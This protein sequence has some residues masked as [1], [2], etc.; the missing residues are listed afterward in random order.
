VAV[1]SLKDLPGHNPPGLS[2]TAVLKRAA[3]GDVLIARESH[4]FRTLPHGSVL[5]TSSVRRA[6]QLRWLRP[7]FGIVE[8]RGNVQT[9]LRKLGESEQ[10]AGIIL[11]QAGLERLGYDLGL[12]DG[13]NETSEPPGRGAGGFVIFPIGHG[14]TAMLNP[15]SIEQ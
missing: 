3:V 12:G 6:R 7:D 2:V 5:G 14:L 11:A 4:T 13:R 15:S 8:W 9:R 10:T 1:H